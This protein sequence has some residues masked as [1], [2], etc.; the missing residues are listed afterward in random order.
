VRSR[1]HSQ[2]CIRAA[3]LGRSPLPRVPRP[4]YPGSAR[5][6]PPETTDQTRRFYDALAGDYD[7]IFADWRASVRRQAEILDQLIRGQLAGRPL[8]VLDCSCGI[9]TQAIGLALRGY[10]VHATD[11]SAVAVERARREAAVAGAT[12]TF[13][14]ADLRS[15]ADQV[16]GEFD[17]VLSCDNALPHLLTDEELR[18][19]ARNLW[20]K[21]A[22]G[23]LLLASIRDY[24]ALLERRPTAEL[25]RVVDGAEG[26][27]IV[28][29]VWDWE[30]QAPLYLLHHFI[31]RQD[32]AD[33]RTTHRQARYRALRRAELSARLVEAGFRHVGWRLPAESGYHQP[34]VSARKPDGP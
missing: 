2:L 19:A 14:V 20:A 30:P 18:R 34:I 22:P 4:P 5:H 13:G 21:L 29:Q 32:G 9:G 7:L 16:T 23:G 10:R 33:W 26:R 8:S 27:R 28:F 1:C 6:G 12:L 15:L 17:V 3:G 25:P 31:L 11:F 24:D